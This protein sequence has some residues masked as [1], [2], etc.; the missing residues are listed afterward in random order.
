MR[1]EEAA[2]CN[3][4][5]EERKAADERGEEAASRSG[6]RRRAADERGEEAA[7][8]SG[9]Q[10][11]GEILNRREMGRGAEERKLYH[12]VER[13]RRGKLQMR[14]ESKLHHAVEIGG[15]ELQRS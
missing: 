10:R 5:M 2:S 13:W 6:E 1:G 9:E 12:A 7:S 8:R 15:G 4:E 3:G 11:R 14:E